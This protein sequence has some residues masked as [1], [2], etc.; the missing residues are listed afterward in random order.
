MNLKIIHAA[1]GLHTPQL[2]G[3]LISMDIF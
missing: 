3:S 2:S 1:R